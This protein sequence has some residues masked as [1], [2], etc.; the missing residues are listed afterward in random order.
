MMEF[1]IYVPSAL[2]NY[3]LPACIIMG[4]PGENK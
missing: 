3:P 4:H 1:S 2:L